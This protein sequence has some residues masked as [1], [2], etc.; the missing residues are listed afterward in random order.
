MI[1]ESQGVSDSNSPGAGNVPINSSDGWFGQHAPDT[2]TIITGA[3]IFAAHYKE[4]LWVVRDILHEGATVLAGKPKKLASPGLRSNW[5]SQWQRVDRS[6][7][8]FA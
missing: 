7:E 6:W 3:S 1:I 8:G 4:T 5:Q 2:P